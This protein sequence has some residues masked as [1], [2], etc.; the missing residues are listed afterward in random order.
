MHDTMG[1]TVQTSKLQDLTSDRGFE[2]LLGRPNVK[3]PP[4]KLFMSPIITEFQL[5]T[6]SRAA[7]W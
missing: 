3:L 2:A 6:R 4:E 7:L 5:S 1:P